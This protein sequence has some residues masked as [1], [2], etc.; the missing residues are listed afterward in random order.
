MTRE[1]VF[2]AYQIEYMNSLQ[3]KGYSERSMQKT[4]FAIG[5]FEIFCHE[6]RYT[7]SFTDTS[8]SEFV[9]WKLSRR[10]KYTYSAVYLARVS[11]TILSFFGWYFQQ[12][13]CCRLNVSS[14]R[15]AFKLVRPTGFEPVTY[16]FGGRHSIQLS[17]ER[18][19]F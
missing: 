6:K 4:A 8:V 11:G 5:E 13:K 15:P 14:V 9:N 2:S 16:G 1:P 17:Y 7:K 19:I 18:I 3:Q 12:S 10:K